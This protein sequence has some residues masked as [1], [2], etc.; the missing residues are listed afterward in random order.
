[1]IHLSGKRFRGNKKRPP[2]KIIVI[3]DLCRGSC[4]LP[5]LKKRAMIMASMHGGLYAYDANNGDR[6]IRIQ[7]YVS[8]DLVR[9]NDVRIMPLFG[10]CARIPYNVAIEA[11]YRDA[12]Y[13]PN[14]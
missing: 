2:A 11:Y 13:L 8:L 7:R 1:M 5:D 12:C 9:A 3:D 14:Q 6:E 4:K 10:Y